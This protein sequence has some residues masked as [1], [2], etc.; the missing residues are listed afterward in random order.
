[1][2]LPDIQQIK[3]VT[4]NDFDPENIIITPTTSSHA[5]GDTY[6]RS[7][8][9]YKYS[10]NVP[11]RDLV[12]TVPRNPD[13]YLV[14]R[15]VQKDVFTRGDHK[16]ET[17]RYGS[18]LVLDHNND[19]HVKLYK[20]FEMAVLKIGELTGATVSFP[21][22]DTDQHTVLYTN[23]IHSSEMRMFSSAYTA[24]E[25][26]DILGCKQCLVR[27]ALLLT[28]LKKSAT[29]QKVKLQI[30]QMYVHKEIMNFPLAYID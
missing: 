19:H 13:A 18:Q 14:C 8:V 15:G 24:D 4:A 7:K 21:S 12:I 26:L 5:K 23:L 29:E 27:P 22:A 6:E 3:W 11:P 30:S 2:D 9:Q 1:M 28:L 25:Q 10:P 16:I 20:A 17:N